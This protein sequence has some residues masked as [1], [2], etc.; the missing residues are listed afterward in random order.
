MAATP[1]PEAL[2]LARFKTLSGPEASR[3]DFAVHFNPESL[4]YTVQNTLKEEGK[5]AKKKQHVSQTSAKLTMQ[6]VFDTT[7][8]GEDVRVYTDEMAKLLQ[9][10]KDGDDKSPPLVEFGWGVYRFTGLVEQYKETIDFFAAG[11]VPLRSSVDI[12]LASQDVV[13]ESSHNPSASVDGDLSAQEPTVHEQPEPGQSSGPSG[14]AGL[15]NALGDPRA[16]RAI[17][18]L[19]GSSSLRFGAGAGLAVGGGISLQAAAAFSVGASAGIGIGAGAGI[20]IGGGAGIG[21]GAGAGIGIG[22]G[23][24][25]GAGASAGAGFGASAGAG[26]GVSAGAG[27]GV[28]AGGGVGVSAGGGLG[29]SAASG[30]AASAGT[31]LALGAGAAASLSASA[32]ASLSASAGASGGA[33]A[34]LRTTSTTS[35]SVPSGRGLFSAGASVGTGA[36]AQFAA[37]GRA[38]ARSGSS[39]AADVGAKTDLSARIT[40][41]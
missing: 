7:D 4:Q 22:G 14:A 37:G 18:A 41:S 17:A 2:E 20:G 15:A 39:L 3:L 40:F 35:L 8:T 5:G 1:T 19:N 12:T 21:I 23:I 16:A 13:F 30:F 38:E 32:G 10:Y 33:F 31:G 25:I 9:P 6:L 11:G 28:S 26:F 29:V 27:F 24:G 34:N 36:N